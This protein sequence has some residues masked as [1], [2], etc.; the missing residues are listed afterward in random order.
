M[1]TQNRAQSGGSQ[2]LAPPFPLPCAAPTPWRAEL[3]DALPIQAGID[4]WQ[5][6][7][8]IPLRNS[9]EPNR[10]HTTDLSDLQ[11]NKIAA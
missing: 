3:C 11:K 8:L 9:D 7:S 6:S 2:E 1:E 10:K 5:E 4:K